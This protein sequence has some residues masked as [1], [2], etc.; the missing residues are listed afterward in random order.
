MTL[1]VGRSSTGPRLRFTA[2]RGPGALLLPLFLFL[3]LIYVAPLVKV[4]MLSLELPTF[5]LQHYE[6]FFTKTVYVR[7]L[8]R[9]IGLA[10]LVALLCLALGYPLA[11]L[12]AHA[13]PTLRKVLLLLVVIPYLTS[14]LVRSYALIIILSEKGPINSLLAAFGLTDQPVQLVY[15]T[16]G[17]YVGMVHIMLPFMVLS[18]YGVLSNIDRRLVSAAQTLGAGPVLSFLRIYLPLSL[19]GILSGC[20]IVFVMSLGFFITPA[21]LGGLQDVMLVNLI[22]TQVTRLGNWEFASAASMVLLIATFG[23]LLGFRL[24]CG[25]SLVTAFLPGEAKKRTNHKPSL[26]RRLA[27]A[28]PERLLDPLRQALRRLATAHRARQRRRQLALTHPPRR[29]GRWLGAG[30]NG[31][32]LLFLILPS[33]IVVVMSFSAAEFITFPPPGWSTK[34]YAAYFERADWL[35]A[36]GNSFQVAILATLLSTLLGTLGAYGLVRGRIK[37]KLAVIFFI[38]SPIIVPPMVLGVGLYGFFVD[39]ELFGTKL[40]LVL[41]HSIGATALVFIAVSAALTR[42]DPSLERAAMSLGAGPI[43]TF[44]RVT[45]PIIKPGV[46]AGAVF[47]F[48]QSFDEL[49]ITMLIA[50]IKLDTLPLKMWRNLKNEIDPVIAS[51]SV[52]LIA[53]PIVAVAAL[54]VS[55]RKTVS[56]AAS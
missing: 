38:L 45:L 27:S 33:I 6:T 52:L 17:V 47:A 53:L 34:W 26:L 32:I 37:A 11:Y 21:L 15:N 31:L 9:T 3:L 19:P 12:L 51:V 10:A 35:A 24:L 4:V 29:Y 46:I 20:L 2:L 43:T 55:Q 13:R 40:G 18:L 22:S 30:F 54:I 14:F 42:F 8:L 50:G 23:F 1:A 28:V 41:A 44:R 5:T 39:L 25:A 36:T 49:V 48:I 16:I 7:V 56:R